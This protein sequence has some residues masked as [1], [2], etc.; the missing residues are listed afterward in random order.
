LVCAG[1]RLWFVVG[2]GTRG[3]PEKNASS[4][5]EDYLPYLFHN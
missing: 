4:L 3:C 2:A 5:A 1:S